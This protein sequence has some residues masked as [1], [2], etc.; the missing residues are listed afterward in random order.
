MS[1]EPGFY[2]PG[3][4]GIRLEN[5][6]LVQ[7]ASMAVMPKFYRFET[8]TWA[9]FDRLLIEPSLL[10]DTELDWLDRYHAEVL[11]RVGPHVGLDVRDWLVQVCAP[12][13]ALVA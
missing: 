12:L 5:L 2:L 7:P 1:N 3:E 8:L 9:P 4:Y 6:V 13:K 10:S 11:A